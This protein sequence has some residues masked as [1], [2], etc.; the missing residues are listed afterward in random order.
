[1]KRAIEPSVS[2]KGDARLFAIK[3]KERSKDGQNENIC[4]S[5]IIRINELV[6]NIGG[7]GVP[8]CR[9]QCD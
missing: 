1:M 3:R 5:G 9:M 4:N 2:Q 7:A 6:G 8:A